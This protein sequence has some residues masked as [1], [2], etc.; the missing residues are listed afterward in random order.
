MPAA[1]RGGFLHSHGIAM[2][3]LLL[4]F[5]AFR[6]A[7]A[8][9]ALLAFA[10]AA[11]AQSSALASFTQTVNAAIS[12]YNR[13]KLTGV[14]PEACAA[15]CLET[16]RAGWCRSFDF[17]KGQQQCDLSDKRASDVGGLK[18]DYA[19]HPYDHYALIRDRGR[20]NPIA[21][22]NGRRHVL[23]IGIDGL[24]G[25]ALF[26]SGCVATPAMSALAQSGAFHR[27]VLAGGPQ[28]TISGPGWATLFTGHWADQH[29]VTSN[30]TALA[31]RKPHV[32]DLIKQA[33]PTA[34]V[35]V[36][37]DWYNITH[38]LKPVGADFVVSNGSKNSQQAT[39]TV[40]DWLSW[41]HAP[42]AIF[43]YLH[44]VD[45][46]APSYDPLNAF[47]Q[48]KIAAEDAQIQQV[49]N[50]LVARP[51]FAQEEW[52]IAVVSDHGGLGSNHG[53][54]S[55]AERNA[56]LILSSNYGQPAKP[57]YCRGDLTGTAMPQIDALTPH[58]LDFLGL[59][60]PAPGRKH[61][62]CGV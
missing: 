31:M 26:C 54:Q 49:L 15:A 9:A 8:V 58:V 41:T 51:T 43:Y 10:Q 13:E 6:R 47:Y 4:P 45:V 20:P 28:A 29:G 39:D 17:Y 14:S 44:N 36:V 35:G 57:P 52:L 32:F 55:A 11:P 40:K 56:L 1:Y 59:A 50:A 23:V 25:D 18:T 60:N 38:N 48:G 19:G 61:P 42:T 22:S 24:R 30:D 2:S 33:Y 34:S 27:N 62:A 53:G 46:H 3:F 21:G 5:A 12:G 16:S 37:G 7:L